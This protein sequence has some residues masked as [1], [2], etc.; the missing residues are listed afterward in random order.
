MI[1]TYLVE[2]KLGQGSY[3]SVLLCKDTRNNEHYA[4]KKMNKE[5]F[6]RKKQYDLL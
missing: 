3:A 4:L 1:N 2:K 6:K 5:E